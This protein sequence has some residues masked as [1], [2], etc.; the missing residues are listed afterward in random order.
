MRRRGRGELSVGKPHTDVAHEAAGLEG[1]ALGDEIAVVAPQAIG[2]FRYY[3]DEQ[4][5]EWSEELQQLHGYQP[6]TVSPTTELVL[7]HKH[8]EDRDEVAANLDVITHTRGA[9]S[10]RHRIVDT[11]GVVRWVVVVGDQFFDDD[12]A[13][14]GTHGFY[15]DVTHSRYQHEDIVTAK[16]SDIAEKHAP[17]EHAKGMLM[18]IYNIDEQV[19]FDLLR[20]LSQENNVKLNPLARRIISDLRA[21]APNHIVDRDSFNHTLLTAHQRLSGEDRVDPD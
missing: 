5:W 1:I 4:R 16:V 9:Y 12:G 7:A 2:W 10:S 17:I 8:S 21:I 13:V 19:A 11:R 20:W 18:L 15:I 6:G 3:F 14:I